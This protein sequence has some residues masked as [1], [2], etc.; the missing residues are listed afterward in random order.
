MSEIQYVYG[1]IIT[2]G[3]ALQKVVHAERS[4][5]LSPL[6]EDCGQAVAYHLRA[7]TCQLQAIYHQMLF[8]TYLKPAIWSEV[9]QR[10]KVL[11]SRPIS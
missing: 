2:R 7:I 10:R 4:Y 3:D 9:D 1:D 6:N 11:A 5:T 8:P